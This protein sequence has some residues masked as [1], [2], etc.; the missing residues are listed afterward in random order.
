MAKLRSSPARPAAVTAG[1]G[2]LLLSALLLLAAAAVEDDHPR[3]RTNSD[4][5]A[6][7]GA[8]GGRR[9]T[10]KSGSGNIFDR[11]S[12]ANK[13]HKGK[14]RG[15]EKKKKQ[16]KKVALAEDDGVYLVRDIRVSNEGWTVFTNESKT[17]SEE[18]KINEL[19]T[20]SVPG[21]PRR[22]TAFWENGNGEKYSLTFVREKL[23]IYFP[24]NNKMEV[25]FANVARVSLLPDGET[26]EVYKTVQQIDPI[27][28]E[29]VAL[30]DQKVTS[31]EFKTGVRSAGET[32]STVQQK[33]AIEV[34]S[35][36]LNGQNGRSTPRCES[37]L[38]F[39][40]QF[41][42]V[43]KLIGQYLYCEVYVSEVCTN[44]IK[45]YI[46]E[47]GILRA[48]VQW[49]ECFESTKTMSIDP[50]KQ[51]IHISKDPQVS[52]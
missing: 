37:S 9:R 18:M 28:V 15:K 46:E 22:M 49:T 17:E 14:K 27:E 19:W 23:T 26:G 10:L 47:H 52:N 20:S 33:D 25:E 16:K 38:S 1:P 34:K 11:P 13:S 42:V 40:T 50:A 4:P 30:N 8:G 5:T 3:T 43:D 12:S 51:E 36:E 29:S 39:L 32:D 7:I 45:G 6:A 48:F 2:L 41:S 21:E 35:V 31:Q 24:S 44:F